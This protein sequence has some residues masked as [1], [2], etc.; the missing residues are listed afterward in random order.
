MYSFINGFFG[1]HQIKIALEDRSKMNFMTEWGC[2]QYTAMPFRLKNAPEFFSHIVIDA[3][4][5]F[6]HKF[7]EVYLD[8]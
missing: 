7:L 6:S 8:D 2:F 3:F 5:Y 1:Y 4:K